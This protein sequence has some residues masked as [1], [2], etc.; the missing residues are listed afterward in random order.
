MSNQSN[1]DDARRKLNL[2]A[3]FWDLPKFKDEKYLRKFLRDKKGESGYY[4]AM[5][6][7]LEYGRVVD[8]FSFF[9]IH[10][11]AESLPKLKLTAPSVKKWKRMIEVY[12]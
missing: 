10:E 12:G 6:R 9:N 7:F 4:W 5:N 3:V 1:I 11:I 2:N 8:T